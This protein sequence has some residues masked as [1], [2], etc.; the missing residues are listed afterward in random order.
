MRLASFRLVIQSHSA[1]SS[2]GT[3]AFHAAC[4]SA[5]ALARALSFSSGA[6]IENETSRTD[7]CKQPA[8]KLCAEEVAAKRV[9]QRAHAGHAGSS[10]A[11]PATRAYGRP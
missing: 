5:M 1:S 9:E 7:T 6:W 10:P 8:D 3:S 2:S 4:R 11:R